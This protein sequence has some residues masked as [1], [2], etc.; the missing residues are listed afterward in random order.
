MKSLDW[1]IDEA[2][3]R[4]G[5]KSDRELSKFL[6]LSHVAS[7][8]WRQRRS[9]PTDDTM[10]RLAEM[11]HADPQ[12]AL[13][14]LNAWRNQG[15]RAAP[16]YERMAAMMRGVVLGFLLIL[17]VTY[18]APASAADFGPSHSLIKSG[19]YIMENKGCGANGP[20]PA[21]GQVCR[22]SCHPVAG[23]YI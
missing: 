22:L 19:M 21:F 20:A 1:Y 18:S 3:A 7:N 5:I 2:K 16:V 23:G 4:S 15:T 13:I 17:A 14:E 10:M 12:L 6:G 8:Y 11:A 9:Y